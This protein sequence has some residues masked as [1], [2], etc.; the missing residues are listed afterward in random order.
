VALVTFL[1]IWSAYRCSFTPVFAAGELRNRV[2]A[3]P[4]IFSRPGL[5]HSALTRIYVPAPQFLRGIG[6][7]LRR[8]HG[9]NWSYLLGSRRDGGWWY[10]F[11]VVLAIKTP[12]GFL[13]LAIPGAGALL[14]RLRSGAWQSAAP[15][16]LALSVLLCCLA[17]RINIGVRHILP[18]YPLL[19]LAAGSFAASSVH[20]LHRGRTVFILVCMGWCC[21]SS[22]L[23][24]PDYLAYFNEIA[25]AQPERYV[26]NSDLDWG[27]DLARLSNRLGQLH[28][29]G[30]MLSYFGTMDLTRAGLPAVQE[31]PCDRP[32]TGYVAVSVTALY[33]G[34][35]IWSACPERFIQLGRTAPAERVGRSIFLYKF[36]FPSQSVDQ[37]SGFSAPKP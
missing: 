19:S 27:Q 34:R 26:L 9:E 5:V 7:A 28:A 4:Q 23:A 2:T 35:V 21:V 11:P 31:I 36:G 20:L 32:L 33:L 25:D 15:A 37:Y 3:F 30:V 12:L 24:H 8:N 1:V 13:L 14:S 6:Q 29:S 10:F 17:T 18:I 22:A 16:L